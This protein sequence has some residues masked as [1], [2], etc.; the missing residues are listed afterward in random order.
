MKPHINRLAVTNATVITAKDR[1]EVIVSDGYFPLP[2]LNSLSE[3]QDLIL[4]LR[5]G[6]DLVNYKSLTFQE[7]RC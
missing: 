3:G 1:S 2:Y 4:H 5:L 7:N 6:R